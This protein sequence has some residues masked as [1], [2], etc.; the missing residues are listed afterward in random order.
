MSKFLTLIYGAL[1]YA[2]AMATILYAIAF[3]G[4]FAPI[5]LDA[6]GPMAPPIEAIVIDLAL[7][8]V[9]A[10][11]HSVMARPAFKAAWTRIVPPAIERST[12]V[13]ASS[14]ALLLLYWQWRPM[15]TVVWDVQQPIATGALTAISWL[16]WGV[17]FLSTFLINHFDLFGLAQVWNAWRGT[18][19]K[20]AEFRTPFFYKVVRHPLYVGF[21]LAFWATPRM[22]QSHLLFAAAATGYIFIGIW[23][24]ERDLL[25]HFGDTYRRYRE[26]VSM[27]VPMPP[28]KG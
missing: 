9:F 6:G 27:I 24:E 11:Q 10:V 5:S 26:R 20:P 1:C 23:L 21:L 25:A 28:R 16:G 18:A 12:Y 2:L 17:L 7:L 22:T 15:G 3:I 19:A 13:L 4:G 8:G 14:L